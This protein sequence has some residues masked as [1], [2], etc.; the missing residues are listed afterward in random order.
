MDGIVPHEEDEHVE[1][2]SPFTTC[3]LQNGLLTILPPGL[4]IVMVMKSS[5]TP[6]GGGSAGRRTKRTQWG[7]S[8]FFSSL[9]EVTCVAS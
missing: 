4:V 5:T 2:T 3:V 1:D 7:S 8:M 6:S 9:V